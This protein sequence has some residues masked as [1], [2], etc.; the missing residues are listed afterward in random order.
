MVFNSYSEKISVAETSDQLN[1]RTKNTP[2]KEV[3]YSNK[4]L[5][6]KFYERL[7]SITTV[8]SSTKV[9]VKQNW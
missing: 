2:L 1:Y 9:D 8:H 6:Y 7:A 4:S 5:G 3:G